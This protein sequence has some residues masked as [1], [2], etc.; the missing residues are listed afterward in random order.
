MEEL[1]IKGH[2]IEGYTF[3]NDKMISHDIKIMPS[4]WIAEEKLSEMKNI[5]IGFINPAYIEINEIQDKDDEYKKIRKFLNKYAEKYAKTNGITM[6]ELKIE[7]I[8]YGKTE[9]VYV[10]SEKNGK[11]VTLLVKQPLLGLEKLIKKHKIY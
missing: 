5:G 9:L 6:E 7:F 11:R 10:L 2:M 4:K 8:N 3:F 1:N